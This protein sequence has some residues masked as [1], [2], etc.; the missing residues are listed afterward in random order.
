MLLA[1]IGSVVA[2]S[3]LLAYLGGQNPILNALFEVVVKPETPFKIPF[4]TTEDE[5]LTKDSKGS[6]VDGAPVAGSGGVEKFAEALI[7]RAEKHQNVKL[8]G[9]DRKRLTD[10]LMG[11]GKVGLGKALQAAKEDH[12]P[13]EEGTQLGDRL[14]GGDSEFEKVLGLSLNK[15]LETLSA[16][17]MIDLTTGS[18]SQ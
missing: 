6:S 10:I 14:K 9:A 12:L 8:G 16:S 15:F 4:F 7:R 13:F 18:A 11:F 2:A 3:F 5:Q 1:V 17:E